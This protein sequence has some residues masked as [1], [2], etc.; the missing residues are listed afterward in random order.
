MS[1][2]WSAGDLATHD[3]PE[4]PYLVKPMIPLGGN[5]L[6]HGKRGVGKTQFLMTLANSVTNGYP[7]LGRWPVQKGPMVIVQVDM[8][9]QIQQ[10]RIIKVRDLLDMEDIYFTF[11]PSM[12]IREMVLRHASLVDQIREV[13]PV[14]VA[15]DTL[16]KIHRESENASE[17]PGIVYGAANEIV[18][19]ATHMFSH[20]DKKTPA[21]PDFES[22]PEEQF[23]G[24]GAWIDDAET[25]IQL[26][27]L[28]GI[29]RRIG[30]KFHKA[31]TAPDTEK[32]P[33]MLEMDLDTM[34]LLPSRT[35]DKTERGDPADLVREA[36]CSRAKAFEL[37]HTRPG[38]R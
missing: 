9:P 19:S 2:L 23:R 31:R 25:S 10:L 27:D 20:H 33:V 29:P 15:W 13:E 26:V 17:S 35:H 30:L 16:R 38:T 5:V 36:K 32:E 37:L 28:G 22:D 6:M 3:F 24:S 12:N 14:C 7:F 21:D 11:P 34:L 4:P 8:T 18:P 1:K